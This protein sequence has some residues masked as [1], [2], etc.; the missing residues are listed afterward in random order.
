M[1]MKK[2]LLLLVSVFVTFFL[3]D[4]LIHGVILKPIYMETTSLWRAESEMPAFMPY[5]MLGQFLIS[6]FFAWIFC[7]GYK[8]RGPVEGIR[9]GL[10]LTGFMAGNHLVMYA[11]QPYP[12][13][14]V[15][16]WI[17][18]CAAQSVLAGIIA[19]LVLGRQAL[20]VS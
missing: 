7:H 19:S 4:F 3:T 5:M 18:A 17:V 2:R 6:F 8:G 15:L 16:S 10:L 20:P 13:S 9:F 11:A 14:L 12:L 1:K